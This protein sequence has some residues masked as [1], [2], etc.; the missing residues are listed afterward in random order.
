MR[1]VVRTL[2]GGRRV[3]RRKTTVGGRAVLSLLSVE[4]ELGVIGVDGVVDIL[5]VAVLVVDVARM[6]TVV[7]VLCERCMEA[8]AVV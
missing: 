8:V 1:E 5:R 2:G 6:E 4:I 3:V 7:V